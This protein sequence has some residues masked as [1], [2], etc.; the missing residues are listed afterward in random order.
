MKPT[1]IEGPPCDCEA[2]VVAGVS[3][4]PIRREPREGKWMHGRELARWYSA[5]DEFRR[6]ARAAVGARGRH[7]NGFERIVGEEG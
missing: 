2:C 3:H 1:D 6:K 5:R 7:A 4:Q